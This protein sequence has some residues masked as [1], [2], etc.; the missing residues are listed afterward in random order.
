VGRAYAGWKWS[1]FYRPDR[2]VWRLVLAADAVDNAPPTVLWGEPQV[3]TDMSSAREYIA[4]RQRNR[5]GL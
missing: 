3:E 5:P 4:R 2:I 1:L